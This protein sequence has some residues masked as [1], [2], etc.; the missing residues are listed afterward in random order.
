MQRWWKRAEP[1]KAV[2]ALLDY[3]D[4]AE[5]QLLRQFVKNPADAPGRTLTSVNSTRD[6]TSIFPR[7]RRVP[8]TIVVAAAS[9]FVV[10]VGDFSGSMINNLIVLLDFSRSAS[11][12]SSSWWP[13]VTE[14]SR[15]V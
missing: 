6:D 12:V 9:Y 8:S 2:E 5:N 14:P 7:L 10:L 11:L 4:R 13:S 1:G 3:L 15:D